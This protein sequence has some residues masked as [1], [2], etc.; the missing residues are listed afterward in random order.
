MSDLLVARR[1]FE[2]VSCDLG[3][4]GADQRARDDVAREVD[5]GVH[6]RVSD[7]RGESA[8]RD[9][10]GR[11]HVADTGREREGGS[12]VAGGKDVVEGIPA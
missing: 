8:Q 3:E 12:G 11:E 5:A 1:A 2:R 10:R 6:A 4:R 9:R 7:D